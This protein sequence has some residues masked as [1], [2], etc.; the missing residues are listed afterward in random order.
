MNKYLSIFIKF[1]VLY[2][3]IS[4]LYFGLWALI[5]PHMLKQSS[6]SKITKFPWA[7]N[8]D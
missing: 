7:Q 1:R 2:F 3:G 5:L 4:V 6:I 8:L